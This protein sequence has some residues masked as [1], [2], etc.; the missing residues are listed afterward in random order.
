MYA[1]LAQRQEWDIHVIFGYPMGLREYVDAGFGKSVKWGNLQLD[2]FSHEFIAQEIPAQSRRIDFDNPEVEKRLEVYQPDVVIIYG[3][4]QP[5]E[6]R[7]LNWAHKHGA[8]TLM[9][10][11]GELRARQ[12]PRKLLAKQLVLP[13]Y[14]RKLSG[15][16]TV[17]DANEEYYLRF[18]VSPL[19][20]FRSPFPIDV[21][22]YAQA[23]DNY[24]AHRRFIREQHQ[25]LDDQVVLSMAGKF[26]PL[27]RQ[28]DLIE[29]LSKVN[30]P[31]HSIVLLFIGSGAQEE[32]LREKAARVSRQ[33]VIFA[34]FVQPEDISA[35]FAAT[36][37]YTHV[38]N[39]D[40]HPLA[41]SEAIYMQC[42]AIV[43]DAVGSA[44]AT[45]DVRPGYNG[46]VFPTGNTDELAGLISRLVANREL[47]AKFQRNSREIAV[48]QQRLANGD[49]LQN[50]L[51]ALG[52]LQA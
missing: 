10:S 32:E 11:D 27:K 47:L 21:E 52:Y 45:D 19:R 36:D 49:G 39:K 12:N 51:R 38:S 31:D 1:Q 14:T 29:A 22:A 6:R 42:A 5:F 4:R 28:G 50:A 37:I 8:A 20:M 3:F 23:W 26:V 41:V 7:A 40:S 24:D 44:G 9:I 2:R 18:G 13:R 17:G 35:Y 34:G 30:A 46:L 15:C 33:R 43:S 25:I 48:H 16:L